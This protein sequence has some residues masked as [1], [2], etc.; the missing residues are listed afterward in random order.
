MIK[1]IL[2]LTILAIT[3]KASLLDDKI[4]NLIGSYDYIKHKNLINYI[5]KNQ[6]E[7]YIGQNIDY[8]KV[9]KNFKKMAY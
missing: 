4:S 9:I 8:I 6:E 5:F 7:Y 1:K 3:L 2:F